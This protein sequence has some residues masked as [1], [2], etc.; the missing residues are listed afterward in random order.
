M[1]VIESFIRGKYADQSL[2]EDGIVIGAGII[3]V[4]DGVTSRG[5]L[6]WR[7]G[8]GGRFAKDVL[9]AYIMEH[10]DEL[11]H[12]TA[13]ECMRTLNCILAEKREEAHPG[14][15]AITE[16]PRACVI[17][18]NSKAR[19]VW[20][21]GDCQC[22]IGGKPHCEGKEADRLLSELRSF[23][24]WSGIRERQEAENG[25][26][27]N[28]PASHVQGGCENELP[29]VENRAVDEGREAILP[30]I[31]KQLWFENKPGPFG[32][33]VLNGRNFAEEMVSVW[34]VPDGAEVI[35]ATDGYPR[36]CATLAESEE[37]LR[38]IIEEDPLCIGVNAGTKGIMEG[39]ESF[40]DRAFV[41]AV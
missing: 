39:M 34:P 24:I 16:Y 14:S 6:R 11:V 2:C 41:R 1:R 36:L 12:L 37:R 23:I 17:L 28:R 15:I 38:K 40:D 19:E 27:E 29:L 32:Y 31:E 21:Y 8:T 30:L 10:E 35:L 22:M 4:I 25:R 33:P 5:K 3:A 20:R 13:V 18:Y 26:S 9:C 7:G